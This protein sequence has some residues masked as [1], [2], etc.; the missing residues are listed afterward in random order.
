[1][2]TTVVPAQITTVQ[3]R[4]AGNFTFAQIFLFIIALI[5]GTVL[6]VII[7]PKMHLDS[8]KLS[9]IVFVLFVLGG[10]SLRINGKIVAEWLTAYTKYS[11]RPRRY[12]FTKNDE[13]TREKPIPIREQAVVAEQPVEKLKTVVT[14]LPLP[15]KNQLGRLLEDPS[16]TVSFEL[17]K[18]GGI[19]VSLT[20][21]KD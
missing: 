10:L 9:L 6:Y 3:D 17:A 8:L 1:M 5:V 19:D 14:E 18:K 4:I 13:F 7:P 21:I 16:V 15:E 2:K 11:K 20:P 12:V